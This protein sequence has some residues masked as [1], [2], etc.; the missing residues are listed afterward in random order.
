T[1]DEAGYQTEMNKQKERARNARQQVE[2]MHV[3]DE[4]LTKIDVDT[5]F[6]GYTNQ[7][8]ETQIV[9]MI[10]NGEFVNQAT[11]GDELF[12]L[13][14]ETPF[15]AESGGQISDTGWIYHQNGKAFVQDVKKAPKGQ[16]MQQVIIKEGTLQVDDIVE[17]AVEKRFRN[18]IVKN[19]TATHLVHQAL[20]DV[21]GT[22]VNQAGSLVTPERL[23]FDFSH[24][25]AITAEE[26][27]Q[28]E[29][30][31]NEKIW[32]EIPLVIEHKDIKE[33]KAMGAMALFGEKYGDVVRVVEIGDYSIELC[34]GCHVNN[35]AEIGI[36]KLVQ[37][38]GIGAGTRRI[39]AVTGEAAYNWISN[40]LSLLHEASTML[41]TT[42]E[43]VPERLHHLYDE[44][45]D[46]EREN[47]SLSTK[48]ANLESG[49]LTEQVQDVEGVPLLAEK[50]DVKDMNQLRNMIDDLKNKLGSS[51]ILLALEQNGKV[52]LASGVSKDLVERGFHAG[53]LI[54][55][56]AKACGG[57]GGGRPDMAQ[58]GGK[59]PN[60]INDALLVAKDYIKDTLNQ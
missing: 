25:Q 46:M 16:F 35:T 14:R 26:L 50:V 29:Q 7:S 60:K 42:D 17:A 44:M 28:I 53:H 36:F 54:K 30:I 41:K 33:A 2:S 45:K 12:M 37:E 23:R 19:H 1:I 21:L 13:L 5:E 58:A 49:S 22:H 32:E 27:E 56:A 11:A 24:F 31:V 3:Q 48:L 20:K 59:D 51:I 57:G 47:E 43:Q 34:G 8:I 18:N 9:K 55:A 4:V 15:Y 6:V 38:S 10:H 39:E 52:Q 40:K